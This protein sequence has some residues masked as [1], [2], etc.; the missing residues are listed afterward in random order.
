MP[1]EV[2]VPRIGASKAPPANSKGPPNGVDGTCSPTAAGRDPASAACPIMSSSAS[3][4]KAGALETGAGKTLGSCGASSGVG[5]T[6]LTASASSSLTGA[7]V[8][9]A[10]VGGA[11]LLAKIN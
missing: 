7:G 2:L 10:G 11:I 4:S 8:N 5:G 9:G 3:P 6:A 1:E